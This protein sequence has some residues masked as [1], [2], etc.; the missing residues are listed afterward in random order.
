MIIS[1]EKVKVLLDSFQEGFSFTIDGRVDYLTDDSCTPMSLDQ[2]Q[3]IITKMDSK[4]PM[5][6]FK[7][8]IYLMPYTMRLWDKFWSQSYIGKAYPTH[9]MI[10]PGATESDFVHEVGHAFCYRFLDAN[11]TDNC[12]TEGFAAYKKLRGITNLQYGIDWSMRPGELFTEDFRYFLGFGDWENENF[13]PPEPNVFDFMVGLMIG[14]DVMSFADVDLRKPSGVSARTIDAFL[15]GT[16][17]AGLGAIFMQAEHTWAV[18][19]RY[20]AAHAVLESGWGKSRIAKE[21]HNLFGFQAYDN[22][23]YESAKGYPDFKTCIDMVAKYVARNYL[24]P[25]GKYYSGPTLKGMNVHYA[26]DKKWADKIATLMAKI[27]EGKD[28]PTV[29]PAEKHDFT[30]IQGHWAHDTIEKIHKLGLMGGYPD[31]TFKPNQPVTRAEMAVILLKLS[32][33]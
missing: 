10:G 1:A 5:G 25:S 17:L 22:S 16:P 9:L 30:D 7:L 27:K 32:Q 14:D 4:I 6:W 26:T 11:V 21:K 28:M 8:P 19:A 23:P 2:A 3:A 15:S 29:K 13:K 24:D 31:G 12:D 18:S 20:L 33:K